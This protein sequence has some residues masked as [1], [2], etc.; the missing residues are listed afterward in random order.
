[1][2]TTLI[3]AALALLVALTA[4][5]VLPSP[6]AQAADR[7]FAPRFTAND[8]GDIDIFG[9]T[10]M[11]CQT[12]AS[13]CTAARNAPV[14]AVAD[15]SV[16]NNSYNMVYI[17]VDSDSSTFNSSQATVSIPSG[18][19]VLFAG[20]Y[21]G[22]E[23]AAGN[24]G[25]AA[26]NAAARNTVRLKAPGDTSYSTITAT[27]V[28]DGA[29]IYQGY[30]DIT[31]RVAAAGNG[32][33]TVANIQT[34]T[35]SDRLG[36]WTIV[37]AYRDTTQPARNLTVF[38]G[39][40][41]ISSSGGGTISVSG[42]QT[43]P[44]GTVSTTV[45][46]VT[47]EGDLGLVG[48][49]ASLNG[50]ALSDAQ[51]PAT[52][53]FDSRSSRNGVLRTGANPSYANNLG[54]EHSMLTVG[55]TYISNGA[56][57]A[58]IGLS[59]AGDVYAPGVITFATDLYAPRIDQTK[60][61]TDLNG[62]NVE[63]GDVLRYT[64]AGTN[65]G[66]DGAAGFI[67]RDP[68]P[69]DT[70]Y[71]PGSIKL[72]QV[73]GSTSSAS[74]APGDDLAE[75]DAANNRVVARLGTGAS[76]SAGGTIAV[77]KSYA[78]TFDVK[79]N[80]PSP[81]VPDG[82]TITNTVTASFSSAS[83]G[84]ALTA[85]STATVDVVGP[86][87][88]LVKSHTGSL[89]KGG[90][91]TFELDV[92]NVGD[93]KSQGTVTVTD[94]LPAGLTYVSATGTGW[95]CSFA[96]GT[97]TCTRDDS[98]ATGTAY[99]S[100]S[101]VVAVDNDA[102]AQ[103]ANTA[104]VSGGG[105]ALLA[106]NSS[107]D[108]APTV[109]GTDLEIAKSA[110]PASVPVGGIFTFRLKVTNNGPSASTG[111]TILDTLPSGLT[112][113]SGDAGCA[114][115]TTASTVICEVGPLA[116]G[117]STTVKVTAKAALGTAGAVLTNSA[118]VT[119]H[120]DDPSTDDNT[121]AVDVSVQP[122]DL[123]VSNSIV[124]NPAS[125]DAGGTY[126]WRLDVTNL[127]LSPAADSTVRFSVPDGLTVDESSL[128]PRCALDG[129]T[130]VCQLGTVG[131]QADV[132]T[133]LIDAVVATT[134]APAT[135]STLATVQTSEPD[136]DAGND[137]A[138]TA[139][140]VV[141]GA[142]L[143]V[144]ISSSPTS[145]GAGDLLTLSGQVTNYGPGTPVNPVVV[146]TLPAG[147]TFVSAPGNCTYDD[148]DRTVTCDLPADEL[149]PGESVS[150]EIVVR[151]GDSPVGPLTATA[152]VSADTPDGD[153]SNNQ[154]TTSVPVN[155]YA[156]LSINKTVNRA[157]ASPGDEVVYALTASNFGP[158][159]AH[160]VVISDVLPAGVTFAGVD[161]PSCTVSGNE[162]TCP[163]G[164]VRA[165]ED[166]AVRI[167]ATVDPIAAGTSSSGHQ[168]DVTKVET[169]LSAAGAST[170]S[171]TATCPSG[172]VATDGSVRLDAVDQGSGTFADAIVLAD[173]VTDDGRG[174]TGTI[175]NEATGQAQG[176]VN[177]VCLSQ[178]TTSGEGHSHDVVLS[179]P[180]VSSQSWTAGT[181][182]V[183]LSCS[184]GR[185]ATSPSFEFV[186]GEGV[187][188]TSQ[189]DGSGWHF[190]VDVPESADATFA[191]SCLS[192]SLSVTQGHTHDLDLRQIS[193]T[194]TVQPGATAEIQLTCG[195]LE[196]GIVASYDLDPGLV[197]LGSDPQPKTRVFKFF[198]PT[199]APLTARVGLR[200]LSTATGGEVTVSDITNTAS[201]STSS[202]DNT[203]VNDQSSATF[204]AS[205][206]VGPVRPI[207]ATS[208]A[209]VPSRGPARVKVMIGSSE[210]RV[211]D[212]KLKTLKRGAGLR[213]GAVVAKGRTTLRPGDNTV[214]V[215]A[216]KK[217]AKDVRKG[218]INRATMVVTTRDGERLVR[219][220][221][222]T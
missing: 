62:G 25:S 26:P 56:T 164:T 130:V 200:C 208:T 135:I 210:K 159:N 82:T 209:T 184:G 154:A 59:T 108:A 177:V 106:N 204:Q 3:R 6:S 21:W 89:V 162:V 182:D 112:F 128:D 160:D 157:Q 64:I 149:E 32:L 180:I 51:H 76:A 163:V 185:L 193:G 84:T 174:W 50:K 92:S 74:D 222:L 202:D 73:T 194:V 93:A 55:N 134:G 60:T 166:T 148:T 114:S 96:T 187:V 54:F 141:S 20:L 8:T 78:L 158:A 169:H 212:V 197:S 111:S 42:F 221:R 53:F 136:A 63:Q 126:T 19:S 39:L 199:S 9:N 127:G 88:E 57:S 33:Y 138:A 41:S 129:A 173:R 61:V 131:P 24:G 16:I 40:K 147:T 133:I 102:P 190:T 206:A 176:K 122:V 170:A 87:L 186:S 91:A 119:A 85:Q 150:G 214:K 15:S 22:G 105:D 117:D 99:P 23:V 103:V 13:G 121:S 38:D 69:A 123:A 219:T 18:A 12:S 86:D 125:L 201:V 142:D 49:G 83:L 2:R 14:S 198:N 220:V 155:A 5:A 139:T 116:S 98:L 191:I 178:S 58:T 213:K 80:G 189:T 36:G 11:T 181:W 152:T 165:G 90:Q 31:S 77:G 72:T 168:L 175:R 172:Y 71:V 97:L 205:R 46:F 17:D 47:Y 115:G 10:V 107:V 113:V 124:G 95:D 145:V 68:V 30:A 37:V 109:A 179:A 192:K 66:Q 29:I 79:V 140:P 218:R 45:G 4:L 171:A 144:T 132:P 104:T 146:I 217:A 1:M 75:H 216:T 151:V 188:R 65:N 35:G 44:A 215:R 203:T 27:T 153:L 196:K 110:Y 195:D 7:N 70:T 34:A 211:A 183:D 28:D 156:G 143:G 94:T 52:N 120:E 161:S 118:T 48:D 81:V 167:R 43:P 137:S 100:I 101:L 67:L 207:T